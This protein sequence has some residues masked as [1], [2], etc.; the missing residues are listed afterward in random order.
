VLRGEL[1]LL[2][3]PSLADAEPDVARL[4]AGLDVAGRVGDVVEPL[5]ADR[6]A[7]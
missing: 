2:A 3:G 6:D 1:R 4:L 5:L 7:G